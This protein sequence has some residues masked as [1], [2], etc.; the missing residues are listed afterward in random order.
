ML[1]HL[2]PYLRGL[3]Q[4]PFEYDPYFERLLTVGVYGRCLSLGSATQPTDSSSKPKHEVEQ[5]MRVLARS[6]W[7][8]HGREEK[9][10]RQVRDLELDKRGE[11]LRM[12]M[13]R[14][15]SQLLGSAGAALAFHLLNFA[16]ELLDNRRSRTPLRFQGCL[17]LADVLAP[18]LGQALARAT[19]T[20]E[21]GLQ[22]KRAVCRLQVTVLSRAA[23]FAPEID[24]ARTLLLPSP[25]L[26]LSC[27]R[28]SLLAAAPFHAHRGAPYSCDAS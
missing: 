27:S 14:A 3:A 19:S 13:A 11:L 4:L 6:A 22:Y 7:S 12:W 18:G 15:T 17:S 28:R 26:T 2:E 23:R 10:V 21:A 1:A 5:R 8:V 16:S 25:L 9:Q 24:F 20:A